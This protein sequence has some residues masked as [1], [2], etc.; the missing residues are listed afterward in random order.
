MY[1]V[2]DNEVDYRHIKSVQGLATT[3]KVEAKALFGGENMV[4]IKMHLPAGAGSPPH[5]HEH[6]SLVY[7]VAGKVQVVIEDETYVLEA[8]DVCRHPEGVVHG[9]QGLDDSVVLEIKSPAQP[10]EQFLGTGE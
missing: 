3:G 6:E 2:R 8:G 1:V 10:L 4:M 9:I 7:V 5:T